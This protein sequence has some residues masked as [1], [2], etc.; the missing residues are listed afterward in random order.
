MQP[1]LP[2]SLG[3]P[4]RF[5]THT[6]NV[7][8]NNCILGLWRMPT[9]TWTHA[10]SLTQTHT[11]RHIC[12]RSAGAIKTIVGDIG[13]KLLV[14]QQDHEHTLTSANIDQ[15]SAFPTG[16]GTLDRI[17]LNPGQQALYSWEKMGLKQIHS[18]Q[19]C[20]HF[21]VSVFCQVFFFF[22]NSCFKLGCFNFTVISA[23]HG[24]HTKGKHRC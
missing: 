4:A 15:R 24:S 9:H 1:T 18:P 21:T 3:F 23:S 14:S 6:K 16:P 8:N 5:S 7:M 17:M 12:L 2:C 13:W 11:Y 19:L 10:C 20:P 22:L